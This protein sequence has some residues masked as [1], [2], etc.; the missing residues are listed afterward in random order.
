MVV[1]RHG[2]K[3]FMNRRHLLKL[4]FA[5][6][7]AAALKPVLPKPSPAPVTIECLSFLTATYTDWDGTVRV[8]RTEYAVQQW[9]LLNQE[10]ASSA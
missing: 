3:I 6:P 1:P 4:L 9:I 8:H 7:F 2:R 10:L 5:A